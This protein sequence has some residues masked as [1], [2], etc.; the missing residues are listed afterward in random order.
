M[1]SKVTLRTR[2]R[3]LLWQ[4]KGLT[5]WQKRANISLGKFWRQLP[6]LKRN[7]TSKLIK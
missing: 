5:N 3:R 1:P 4:K 2:K 7:K 6:E